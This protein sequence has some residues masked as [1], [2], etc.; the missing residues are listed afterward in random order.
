MTLELWLGGVL[1]LAA[2]IF[3]IG[4]MLRPENY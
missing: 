2:L 4:A 1:F 3:L